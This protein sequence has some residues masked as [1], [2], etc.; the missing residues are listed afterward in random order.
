MSLNGVL[1]MEV[2]DR[3]IT[4]KDFTDFVEGVLDQMQP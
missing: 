4:G 2:Y 1:H 3:P